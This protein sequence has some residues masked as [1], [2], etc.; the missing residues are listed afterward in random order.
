MTSSE[1]GQEI[2]DGAAMRIVK[3]IRDLDVWLVALRGIL[4]GQKGL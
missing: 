2:V 3:L 4:R 1:P